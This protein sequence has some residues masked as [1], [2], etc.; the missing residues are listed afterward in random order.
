MVQ[1]VDQHLRDLQLREGV[2]PAGASSLRGSA[3][4]R[5]ARAKA[6]RAVKIESIPE[7]PELPNEEAPEA[8]PTKVEQADA[9]GAVGSDDTN[10]ATPTD[11]SLPTLVDVPA[12]EPTEGMFG[13]AVAG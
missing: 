6:R 9:G 7:E 12:S 4:F 5:S 3:R 8:Q 13:I 2:A 1:E 11:A 10:P